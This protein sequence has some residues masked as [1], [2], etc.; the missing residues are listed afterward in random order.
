[1]PDRLTPAQRSAHMGKI[2][3]A[4]TKPELLVRRMLHSMGYRYRLQW[5]GVPGRPDVAFPGRKKAI[6]VHGCFWHQHEG[7]RSAHIPSTRTA[8]WSSKFERN[9][10]RDQRV[11]AEARALGWETLVVWECETARLETLKGRLVAFL[12]A[13]KSGVGLHRDLDR[14]A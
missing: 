14:N 9:K 2:R 6:Y 12:G 1:M 4:H 10:A 7:C 8:F 13:S 3:R 11:L 5:K